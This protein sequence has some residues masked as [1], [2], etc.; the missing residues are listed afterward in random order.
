MSNLSN[1][2]PPYRVPRILPL[3]CQA[4][5][6]NK[7]PVQLILSQRSAAACFK[8]GKQCQTRT[9][10]NERDGTSRVARTAK[11]PVVASRVAENK[12]GNKAVARKVVAVVARKVA[13]GAAPGAT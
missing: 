10:K 9:E 2:T 8:E 7:P 12:A 1:G 5:N 13:A 6:C 11:D 3:D 4:R